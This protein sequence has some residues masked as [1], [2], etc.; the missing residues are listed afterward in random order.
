V[1]IVGFQEL[2]ARLVIWAVWRS[3]KAPWKH[4]GRAALQGPRW[5]CKKSRAF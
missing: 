1:A 3:R 5:A 2:D 4:R